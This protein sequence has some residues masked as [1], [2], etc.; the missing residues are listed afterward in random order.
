M[1]QSQL[2]TGCYTLA[3]EAFDV[4]ETI[5]L[6]CTFPGSVGHAGGDGVMCTSPLV[7]SAG[8][9]GGRVLGPVGDGAEAGA[10]VGGV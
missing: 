6:M 2:W 7:H 4:L 5:F 9:A 3:G 8:H 1:C 10:G